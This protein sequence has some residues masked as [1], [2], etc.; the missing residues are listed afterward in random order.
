GEPTAGQFARGARDLAC[1]NRAAERRGTL[2][3]V[4]DGHDIAGD[5]IPRAALVAGV[6][7]GGKGP[8][9]DPDSEYRMRMLINIARGKGG[10]VLFDPEGNATTS[11]S[12][13]QGLVQAGVSNRDIQ[14]IG[15]GEQDPHYANGRQA[16]ASLQGAVETARWLA[17]V[18]VAAGNRL[19]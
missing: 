19:L 5:T 2:Y 13:D 11:R 1:A 8:I 4:N 16:R 18:A 17:L 3:I 15:Y 9:L 10:N 7:S 12:S 6:V 14:V